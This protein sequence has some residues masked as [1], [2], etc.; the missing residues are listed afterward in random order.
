MKPS[1][2]KAGYANM[3]LSDVFTQSFVNSTGVP[4]ELYNNDGSMGAAIGSAIGTGVL[5]A[6]EAFAKTASAIIRV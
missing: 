3:F 5:S 2:I 1:I 6:K 4:V